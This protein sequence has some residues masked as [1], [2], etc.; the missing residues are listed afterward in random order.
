MILASMLLIA[1]ALAMLL[2][3]ELAI[4]STYELLATLLTP[5][6]A[7]ARAGLRRGWRGW[8]RRKVWMLLGVLAAPG[9]AA[10]TADLTRSALNAIAVPVDA[11]WGLAEDA[12]LA[13]QEPLKQAQ[14]EGRA[15]PEATTAALAQVRAR[16]QPTT[17]LFTAIKAAHDEAW[18]A[19][20]DGAVAR[21]QQLLEEI[22]GR[23]RALQALKETKP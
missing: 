2:L 5:L 22:R 20:E 6:L 8:R 19:L 23:W 9:C 13:R 17:D 10:S 14:L 3:C 11:A 15:T 1:Y 4:W 18:K 7:R 16:C 12:C 21:A